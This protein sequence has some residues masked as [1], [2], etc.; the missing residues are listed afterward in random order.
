LVQK[1]LE[2]QEYADPV[3]DPMIPHTF[4][5]EPGLRIFKI[6]NGSWWGTTF[7]G[8]AAPRSARAPAEGET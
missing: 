5:L 2:I 1:D 7:G 8:G 4:V 6:Y 3:H